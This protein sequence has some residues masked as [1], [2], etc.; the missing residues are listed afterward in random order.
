MEA[1]KASVL[2]ASKEKFYLRGSVIC[3]ILS[4]LLMFLPWVSVSGMEGKS[5]V[6]FL[7]N[8]GS[9]IGKV[10]DYT[11]EK[12]FDYTVLLLFIPALLFLIG[13]P[14]LFK[15]W[16]YTK[17][18]KSKVNVFIAC[19]RTMMYFIVTS[20]T[21]ILTNLVMWYVAVK[22]ILYAYNPVQLTVVP[23]LLFIISC[24]GYFVFNIQYY[25]QVSEAEGHAYFVLPKGYD[26]ISSMDD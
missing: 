5:G 3:S 21:T 12:S 18:Q 19:K 24:L 26:N 6:F 7:F 4:V 15:F 23:Y 17:R 13:L 2:P 8:M 22:E 20:L 10:V 14:V 11:G 1:T 9:Y 25:Q 16:V